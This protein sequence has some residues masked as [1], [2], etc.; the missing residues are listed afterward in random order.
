M[1]N[2]VTALS[3]LI[4]G[5]PWRFE[6]KADEVNSEAG[7]QAGF[8]IGKGTHADGSTAFSADPADFPVTWSQIQAEIVRLQAIEDSITHQP[9]RR[10]EYP[11]VGDQLDALYHAG[12]FPADMAAKI[13][14]VKDKYPKP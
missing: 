1:A 3:S 14:A 4:K 2:I 13:K 6:G 11:S 10:L 12:V 8:H 9:L 5:T 7:F